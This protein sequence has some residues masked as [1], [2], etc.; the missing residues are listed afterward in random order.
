VEIPVT[1]FPSAASGTISGTATLTASQNDDL[2][3]GK[4]YVNIHTSANPAGEIRG[5]VSASK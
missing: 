4:M 3:G 1:G 2:L 5:Q